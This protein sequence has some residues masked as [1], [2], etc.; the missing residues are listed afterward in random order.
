VLWVG[1]ASGISFGDRRSFR[2]PR[3]VPAP[4]R[5]QVLGL[6]EDKYRWLWIATSNHVLR[7]NRDKLLTGRPG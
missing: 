1:T 4:L 3:E 2:V 6:A 7:V 5:E